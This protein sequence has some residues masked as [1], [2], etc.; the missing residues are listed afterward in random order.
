MPEPLRL[1]QGGEG[2]R[3]GRLSM[4]REICYVVGILGGCLALGVW[5]EFLKRRVKRGRENYPQDDDGL[6]GVSDRTVHNDPTI[7][8][9]HRL[10]PLSDERRHR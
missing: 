10:C 6:C 1:D 8:I 2:V 7:S 9:H 3:A 5:S 4:L